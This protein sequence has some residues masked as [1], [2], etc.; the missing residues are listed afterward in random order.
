M[1]QDLE[2]RMDTLETALREVGREVANIRREL[3]GTRTSPFDNIDRYL[4]DIEQAIR[5]IR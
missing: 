3:G 4:R 5:R 1:A 2:D